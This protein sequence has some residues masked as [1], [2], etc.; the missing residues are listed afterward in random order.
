MDKKLII[1]TIVVGD[2]FTNC[3]LLGNN[4]TKDAVLIDP[5][6]EAEK[7]KSEIKNAGLKTNA[8]ILTHGHYDHIGAVEY[9][10][11]PV[12][13]HKD[14][15]FLLQDS[16]RNLSSSLGQKKTIFPQLRL[17]NNADTI[18]IGDLVADILHTPG[19]TPGG[20]CIKV[21][22]VLFS[23]DTLFKSGIGRT[24]LPG[25]SYE[26]LMNSIYKKL[27]VLDRDT[28]VLPGHG[29]DTILAEEIREYDFL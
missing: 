14:D 7:V 10:D 12:Y 27:I 17:L 2:L 6:A 9:F 20:I 15:A 13:I 3:Y 5:G 19:H 25:G 16:E 4:E 8:I 21:N 23:G 11:L 29:M 26:Q 22:G 28:L 1:K 24:D 18:S